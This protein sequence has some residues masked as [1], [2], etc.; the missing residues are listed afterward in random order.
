[1]PDYAMALVEVSAEA[2]R[3][4]LMDISWFMKEL[5]EPIARQA[6]FE[7][8]CTGRY[9]SHRFTRSPFGPA[10]AVQIFT[11]LVGRTI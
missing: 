6:N 5:N 9:Y 1:M 7:D 8:N 4:R 10:K 11:K 3:S 2:Y